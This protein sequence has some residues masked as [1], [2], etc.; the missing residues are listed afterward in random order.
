MCIHGVLGE[1]GSRRKASRRQED[2][3]KKT[4]AGKK[5][6]GKEDLGMQCWVSCLVPPH[7]SPRC[8]YVNQSKVR[9]QSLECM[10]ADKTEYQPV[11]L[12]I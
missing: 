10:R 3:K 12:P 9:V 4:L 8:M 11:F 7:L 6:G 1:C 2:Q 5:E